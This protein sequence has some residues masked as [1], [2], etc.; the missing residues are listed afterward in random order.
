MAYYPAANDLAEAFN[1]TIEKLLK[2]FVS[3]SERVGLSHNSENPN[4]IYTVL[5]GLGM[6]SHTPTRNLNSISARYFDN[7]DDR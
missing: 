3:K 7:R 1:K 6:L 4:N 2:K 5:F